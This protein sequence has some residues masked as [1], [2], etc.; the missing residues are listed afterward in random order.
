[1]L[2]DPYDALV[3]LRAK[4]VESAFAVLGFQVG[5]DARGAINGIDYAEGKIGEGFLDLDQL[6]R[7]IAPVVKKGSWMTMWCEEGGPWRWEFDGRR[8]RRVELDHDG[9][10]LERGEDE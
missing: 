7:G 1:M 9:S 10:D 5:R 8:C 3:M 2:E 4:T 6:M